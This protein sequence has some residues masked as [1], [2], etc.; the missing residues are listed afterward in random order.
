MLSLEPPFWN[1][2][3]IAVF[4]DH[5]MDRVFYHGAPGPE[6]AV[7]GGRPMFDIFAY[8]VDLK[9]S[10]IAGTT[11]PD[12]LGAGFLTMGVACAISDQQR[13]SI[14]AKLADATGLDP[15]QITLYPI[16]YRKGSVQ[17][18]ALDKMSAP[19]AGPDGTAPPANPAEPTAGRPTFVEAIMGSATPDLTHDLRSVF[20]L[21]LSQSGVTFL[22]ALYED[23]AAPVGIVFDLVYDGLRQAVQARV[24]AD[25]STIYQHFG[26]TAGVQYYYVRAEVDAALDKLQQDGVIKVELTSQATG[27]EAQKSKELA[28][29]LFRDQ[30]VQQLFRP[31][32][33]AVTPGMTQQQ[34]GQALKQA[35]GS[36]VSLTLEYKRAEEL[37]TVTYDFSERAPEERRHAP[38]AFLPLLVSKQALQ[39]A[40]HRV[41]LGDAFFEALDVL[42]TGP[43]PDDFTTLGIRQVEAK[44]TYGE[45]GDAAA[46]VSETLVFRKDSAGDKHFGAP[47]AGRPSL[48][49]S[50]AAAYDFDRTSDITSDSFKYEL[51]P[52]RGT[53]RVV[54]INPN[55]DFGFLDVELEL[56]R[57]PD[58]LTEAEVMLGYA[59]PSSGFAA[60]GTFHL[61]AAGAAGPNPHWRV[62]TREPDGAQYQVTC[63]WHFTDN[64]S[65]VQPA[66]TSTE[67]L[68]VIE[69]PFGHTRNL[70][71]RPNVTSPA[72]TEVAVEIQYTDQ[73]HG[74]ERTF[75][76]TLNAPFTT[77]TLGWPIVDPSVQK[78]RYRVTTTEPGFVSEGEWQETSEPSIVV[79]S[80]GSRVGKIDIHLIGPTLTELGVDAVRL[81]LQVDP[82]T[83]AEGEQASLLLDD[84]SRVAVS[85]L[86]YPP[87]AP[88]A[89]TYQT[90]AFKRDGTLS[91]SGWT[92][93]SSNLLVISTRNL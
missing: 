60:S 13:T 6:I 86:T 88:L 29:S 81:D 39:Q 32:A 64:T 36:I 62:R 78:L 46:P 65:Y 69:S 59:A 8:T 14:A 26:G 31:T 49:Y 23:G 21:S 37:K 54:L 18:I 67:R 10:P 4:R 75:Q 93:Q 53:S 47:R 11:I 73:A 43:R 77:Q 24:T 85:S 79:G 2:D 90:T 68:L 20:S 56:G 51:P 12:Q 15:T 48:D 80:A 83:G 61:P 1:L 5:A 33:P 44:L 22:Q 27:D 74:Y 50:I 72:I 58:G 92:P 35:S 89:Y 38:Q 34:L 84:S 71:V 45:P 91:V 55:A 16:P 52:R 87:G 19:T 70:L 63:S 30:I 9:Q 42:V 40:V 76:L 28:M 3:G 7:S 17:I 25:V 57:I 66:F 41:G 82:L